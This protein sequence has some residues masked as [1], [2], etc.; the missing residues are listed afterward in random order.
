MKTKRKGRG[1]MFFFSSVC[2]FFF[3]LSASDPL[4]APILLGTGFGFIMDEVTV[5]TVMTTTILTIV[6]FD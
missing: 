3:F 2:H 4:G 6:F 5:S 1:E